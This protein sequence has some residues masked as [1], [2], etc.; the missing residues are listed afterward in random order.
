[1]AR[2]RGRFKVAVAVAGACAAMGLAYAGFA[3]ANTIG[4][5]LTGKGP[6]PG[7]VSVAVGDTIAFTNAENVAH[8]VSSKPLG[9]TTPLIQGGGTYTYIV[10]K[11]GSWGYQV[12]DSQGK[13]RLQGSIAVSAP[14]A[15]TLR[16]STAAVPYGRSVVLR[17]TT[18]L[19]AYPVVIEQQDGRSWAALPN[20]VT[21]TS[22]GSF[23]LS[24]TPKLGTAYRANVLSG[25]IVSATQT[26]TV[27]PV[28][29]LRVSPQKLATAKQARFTVRVSP[30]SA[31]KQLALQ[32]YDKQKKHWRRVASGQ[33]S[34]AG[35]ITLTA[36]ALQG[37]TAY[38][39]ATQGLA[40]G[41]TP[42]VS[43]HVVV[44]GVG[45][46]PSHRKTHHKTATTTTTKSGATH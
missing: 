43:N 6:Q 10:T 5:T 37:Y 23:S 30:A 18:P 19:P 36:T 42:A 45:A 33:P 24:V 25:A 7:T 44:V 4:V 3:L 14:A 31:V 9:F 1:M 16:A 8:I 17:G 22:D 29:T 26:V 27:Q 11:P 41:F 39:A 28:L 2:G 32:Q 40:K 46:P 20:Q 15:I 21:P 38:R 13:N 34:A 12:A 35:T